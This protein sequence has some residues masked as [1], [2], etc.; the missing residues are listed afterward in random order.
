MTHLKS[1]RNLGLFEICVI[2]GFE[3]DLDSQ[4]CWDGLTDIMHSIWSWFDFYP[5]P[6]FKMMTLRYDL[7]FPWY[8]EWNYLILPYVEK[9]TLPVDPLLKIWDYQI[10]PPLDNMFLKMLCH[11]YLIWKLLAENISWNMEL[12]AWRSHSNPL[13]LKTLP[14]QTQRVAEV[15]DVDAS[16]FSGSII[17]NL[18]IRLHQ[19]RHRNLVYKHTIAFHLLN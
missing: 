10:N 13:S 19:C 2:S 6:I 11:L 16:I 9:N 5:H 15:F 3:V 1:S 14:L 7:H 17:V 12:N 18:P 4:F 8:L